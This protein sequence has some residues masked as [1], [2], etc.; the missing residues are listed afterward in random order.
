MRNIF[1]D[2][3]PDIVPNKLDLK[4]EKSANFN[5]K[6]NSVLA[7]SHN[8]TNTS[9]MHKKDNWTCFMDVEQAAQ[10]RAL[11]SF[12]GQLYSACK[13]NVKIWDIAKRREVNQ[14]NFV[15]KATVRSLIT[16]KKSKSLYIGV[17]N[18]IAQYDILSLLCLNKVRIN[19]SVYGLGVMPENSILAAST[20]SEIRIYDTK[21]WSILG[22]LKN[23]KEG[24][25]HVYEN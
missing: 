14:L 5:N 10:V 8:G 23:N 13:N 11:S 17:S 1:Y 20:K 16:E 9:N 15:D 19:S 7:D 18:E 21:N 22:Q 25:V 6:K 4:T 12:G 24:S 3:N 2:D